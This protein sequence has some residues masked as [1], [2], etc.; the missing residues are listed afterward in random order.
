MRLKIEHCLS[1]SLY[2]VVKAMHVFSLKEGEVLCVMASKVSGQSARDLYAEAEKCNTLSVPLL[3]SPSFLFLSSL[4]LLCSL[5][6]SLRF[7][8]SLLSSFRLS[9]ISSLVS[10]LFSPYV[11]VSLSLTPSLLLPGLT[12]A[13]RLYPADPHAQAFLAR[14]LA[15]LAESQQ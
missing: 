8:F 3:S 7:S 11:S 13:L 15:G 12:E 14:S 10:P 5:S 2:A 4:F 1:R 9:L 6:L